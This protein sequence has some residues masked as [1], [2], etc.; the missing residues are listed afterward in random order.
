MSDEKFQKVY[1]K[2]LKYREREDLALRP[3]KHL[4]EQIEMLDG[5]VRPLQLRY[6]Q[7]QAVLHLLS[8]H[9]RASELDDW[10]CVDV[11]V[12]EESFSQAVAG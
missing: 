10:D 1:A 7:V 6:Y 9:D 11:L 8:R 2:L 5:T 12:D 3:T 4:R